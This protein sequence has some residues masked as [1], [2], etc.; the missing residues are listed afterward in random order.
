MPFLNGTG[1]SCGLGHGFGRYLGFRGR[2]WG[3][4]FRPAK[5]Q[6]QALAEYRQAL[7]KELEL[8]KQEEQSLASDK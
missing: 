5:D 7:E 4:F 3:G 2:G 1:G 6:S 8:V